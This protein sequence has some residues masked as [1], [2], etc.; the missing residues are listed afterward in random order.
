MIR[1][2]PLAAALTLAVAGLPVLATPA[3]AAGCAGAVTHRV[4]DVQ[5]GG[6]TTPLDGATVTVRGTVVGDTPGL[7]GFYLQDGGDRRAATSDG[8]FV[9]S[10]AAV[11]LGDTVSVTGTAGEFGGQTQISAR[12][13]VEVCADGDAGD[14]PRPARLDLPADDTAREALE[15]MLVRPADLTVSEVF[16]LTRFGELTLSADGVLVQR[17]ELARPGARAE[18]L[19]ARNRDRAIVLDDARSART[20]LTDRPYLAP[21]NPVRV[22]D[23]ARLAEPV[24]LGFGFSA[25]RLQPAD[26][27]AEGLLRPRDTRPARPERT[28]GNTTV[29]AFNVLN[30]FVTLGGEGRGAETPEQLDAQADKIVPAVRGLRADVVTLME[31]ED[32]D[33]TGFSPGNA[34]TALAELVGR[35]NAAEGREVWDFVPLPAELYAVERDAIRNAIVYRTDRVRAVGAPVGLVDETVWSNA[36]EPQAQTFERAGDR[37]TVV[38]NHF[39]SKSATGATG[40]DEDQGDGQG[41]YNAAR[42][43]QAASLARFV[44]DLRTATGDADVIALGDLNAYTREDPVEVLRSAGLVDLGSRFDE[45]RYSY[46]FQARSGSLDHALATR[47]LTRKVSGVTHWNINAVESSAYQYDGDPALYAP[48][49]FRSSDHDPVIVGLDLRDRG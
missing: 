31:I 12:T 10:P 15:G 8:V 22:G 17:T 45:G 40:A 16:E 23:R 47:E 30:Y 5:G 25:W 24:V 46:V 1:T 33:A 41:A 44:T 11:D 38:A 39:K 37:F 42:T 13:G 43:R 36:R 28:G 32:T 27:T 29:A 9:F 20:S 26:G 19:E 21:Q 7:S 35:L 3:A 34:D 48:D 14:L 2:A 18:R 6:A 49:P 4:G